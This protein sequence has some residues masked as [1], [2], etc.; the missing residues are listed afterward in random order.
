M[1]VRN[2]TAGS[3]WSPGEVIAKSGPVSYR[4]RLT[5]GRERRCHVEQIRKRTV[6]ERMELE[7]P[8]PDTEPT[9]PVV[10]AQPGNPPPE[11]P[12]AETELPSGD[13]ENNSSSPP[14]TVPPSSET[15][16][17]YPARTRRQVDR[18]EPS[19]K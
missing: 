17:I 19:W 12:E 4:V 7:I 3:Q 9:S 18:Y 10:D 8:I 15:V 2:T 13:S 6:E 14:E 5:D 16:R 11:S 1:Y